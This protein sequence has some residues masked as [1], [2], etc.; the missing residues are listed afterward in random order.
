MP[1]NSELPRAKSEIGMD[2][3]ELGYVVPGT[4]AEAIE[5]NFMKFGQLS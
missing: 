2:S 3:P 4:T 5:G 1:Q